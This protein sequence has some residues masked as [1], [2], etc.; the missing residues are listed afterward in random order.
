MTWLV[1]NGKVVH[2]HSSAPAD[3]STAKVLLG[4]E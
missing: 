2:E 4:G 1:E 3:L